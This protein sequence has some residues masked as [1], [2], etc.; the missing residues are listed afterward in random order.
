[1]I[2]VVG[3]K[4]NNSTKTYYFMPNNI[5]IKLGDNVIVET[6]QGLQYGQAVT[7][8]TQ[9]SEESLMSPLKSVIR[10]ATKKDDD[11]N[12]KNICEA[13][14]ALKVCKGIIDEQNLKM[15]IVDAYY[16]YD[17]DKLI[18]R[19]LADNRVDF[20]NLARELA[21]KYKTRIELRQIGAR[22]KAKEVGGCGS[23][24]RALCCSK[25]LSDMDSVSINMAKNQ[26]V[27][28]NPNKINGLCGRL[29]CCLKYEDET[30]KTCRKNLP[31]IGDRVKTEKGEGKVISCDVLAGI[32]KVALDGSGIIEVN[33]C[34]ECK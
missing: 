34:D 20:R 10:I 27:S 33:I 17:R 19:F 31:P 16:T 7:N 26:N 30:Y 6:E 3:I 5:D 11:C 1:M 18:F 12:N 4:L 28:L 2:D 29:L 15:Q 32:Y 14:K 22:D 25:F 9:I 23:C 8:I 24:G 21:A 13:Q